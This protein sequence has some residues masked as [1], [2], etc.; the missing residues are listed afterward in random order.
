MLSKELDNEKRSTSKTYTFRHWF[1]HPWWQKIIRL[2][3]RQPTQMT[4]SRHSAPST[5]ARSIRWWATKTGAK[6]KKLSR[7]ILRRT[8]RWSETL[9]R[10]VAARCEAKAPCNSYKSIR[11]SLRWATSSTKR[12]KFTSQRIQRPSWGKTTF[13]TVLTSNLESHWSY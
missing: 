12:M 13:V 4:C 2:A 11:R 3:S 7:R 9:P 8:R 6:N 10:R 1:K 5:S